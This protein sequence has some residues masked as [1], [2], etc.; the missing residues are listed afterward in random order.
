M[1]I[2]SRVL[3]QAPPPKPIVWVGS[4]IH[5][6]RRCAP[7]VQD[8][9]G[10]ELRTLQHGIM[11]PDWKPM[12]TVGVGVGEIRIHTNTEHR[13]FFVAK[14]HE[15]IYILHIF[16]K[17]SRKTARRDLELGRARFRTVVSSRG[18]RER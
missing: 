10:V 17:R 14:F 18:T 13:I 5:D 3:R 7:D 2:L 9:A 6:M 1:D 16:E 8:A 15:A 11:P 12:P 4:S